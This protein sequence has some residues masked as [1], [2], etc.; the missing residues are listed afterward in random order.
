ML[1]L[2]IP[3]NIGFTRG[4]ATQRG[5]ADIGGLVFNFLTAFLKVSSSCDPLLSL[6]LHYLMFMDVFSFRC[7]RK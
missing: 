3:L 7:F 5:S 6:T 2:D 4:Q 1:Y